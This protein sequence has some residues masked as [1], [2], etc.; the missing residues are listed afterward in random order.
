MA[1]DLIE[2]EK[3][4]R[5]Y[6]PPEVVDAWTEA[7]TRID[8]RANRWQSPLNAYEVAQTAK[9]RRT[10]LNR[11]ITDEDGNTYWFVGRDG[12]RIAKKEMFW[13]AY[14]EKYWGRKPIKDKDVQI[15]FDALMS[16]GMLPKDVSNDLLNDIL[17]GGKTLDKLLGLRV[18][19]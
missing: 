17:G 14:S 4:M 12:H 2:V 8:M 16:E 5:S 10:I 19:G 1:K 3:A 13:G 11:K 6:L 15:K 7:F 18:K 9:D